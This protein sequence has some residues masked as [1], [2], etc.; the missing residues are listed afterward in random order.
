MEKRPLKKF[1]GEEFSEVLD[2]D[3][4]GKIA[5]TSPSNYWVF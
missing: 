5:G 4:S 3:E 1:R 2:T